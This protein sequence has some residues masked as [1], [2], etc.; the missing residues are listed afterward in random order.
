[1]EGA[2][3]G[4][5]LSPLRLLAESVLPRNRNINPNDINQ[6]LNPSGGRTPTFIDRDLAVQFQVRPEEF[7]DVFTEQFMKELADNPMNRDRIIDML[8]QETRPSEGIF[9]NSRT[10]VT[11]PGDFSFGRGNLTLD[12]RVRSIP[13]D[14]MEGLTESEI[15]Y[16]IDYGTYLPGYTNNLGTNTVYEAPEGYFELPL[17]PRNPNFGDDAHFSRYFGEDRQLGPDGNHGAAFHLRANINPDEMPILYELQSDFYSK[18]KMEGE[19]RDRRIAEATQRIRDLGTRETLAQY[20]IDVNDTRLW[21]ETYINDILAGNYSRVLQQPRRQNYRG[22]PEETP[23]M[24]YGDIDQWIRDTADYNDRAGLLRRLIDDRALR[25]RELSKISST[26][27]EGPLER[28]WDR[29][30]TNLFL[31]LASKGAPDAQEI[32][33]STPQMQ[34][35]LYY[36]GAG[37]GFAKSMPMYEKIYNKMIPQ[38]ISRSLRNL[39][40]NP[41]ISMS[42]NPN[43]HYNSVNLRPDDWEKIREVVRRYGSAFP[44]YSKGGAV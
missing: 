3:R 37:E 15:P 5:L 11:D 40:I 38:N 2:R 35:N 24:T 22:R 33:W 39:G 12:A 17:F 8:R 36:G 18:P 32:R 29:T 28:I 31:D 20:G 9:D 43:S 14:N 21:P 19:T 1:M 41:E 6:H 44:L 42:I 30:G 27:T 16:S 4:R 26:R 13:P 23:G 7:N 10:R 25:A 34:G